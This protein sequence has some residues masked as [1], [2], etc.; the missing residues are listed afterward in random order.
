MVNWSGATPPWLVVENAYDPVSPWRR[1][2]SNASRSCC[3]VASG[4]AAA[5]ATT[6]S[7]ASDA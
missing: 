3:G 6:M 1:V 2:R 7:S 5:A 4:V